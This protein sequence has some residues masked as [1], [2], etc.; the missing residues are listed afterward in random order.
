MLP[1]ESDHAQEMYRLKVSF[2]SCT[3][4]GNV[5]RWRDSLITSSE[6]ASH[7]WIYKIYKMKYMAGWGY[8]TSSLGIPCKADHILNV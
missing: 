2:F 3:A 7:I 6:G 1:S 8:I 4:A 5:G